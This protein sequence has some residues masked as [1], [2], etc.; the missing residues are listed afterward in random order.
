MIFAKR[1]ESEY[2]DPT[3]EESERFITV[4]P[5]SSW[6][7]QMR[8]EKSSRI[9]VLGGS[10]AK[11]VGC[12]GGGFARQLREFIEKNNDSSSYLINLSRGGAGASNY[13]GE[14]F[15]F[16]SWAHNLWP[17]IIL[18]ETAVNDEFAWKT[19]QNIDNFIFLLFDK[20]Q[21]KIFLDLI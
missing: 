14:T 8:R 4:Y 13:V 17:N 20:W 11:G 18:F 7:A 5:V 19:A 15:E 21:T 9:L 16:E 6:G 12:P 3:L 1:K 10:N 2:F